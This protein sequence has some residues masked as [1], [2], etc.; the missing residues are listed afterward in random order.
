MTDKILHECF[1]CDSV[2]WEDEIIDR[3]LNAHKE[4]EF[5][6]CLVKN[7]EDIPR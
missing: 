7:Y 5:V 2:L 6:V 3:W 4:H 1:D